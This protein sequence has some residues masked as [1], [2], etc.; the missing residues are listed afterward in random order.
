[1]NSL[2]A[3]SKDSLETLSR[4]FPANWLGKPFYISDIYTIIWLIVIIQ[5]PSFT[6][7]FGWL[8]SIKEES[9]LSFQK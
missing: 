4:L 2:T 1:M 8:I 7:A 5:V 3:S 9:N 6:L